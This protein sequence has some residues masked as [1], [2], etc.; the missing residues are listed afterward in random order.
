MLTQMKAKRA[1]KF[2]RQYLIA[3]YTLAAF[4]LWNLYL[5]LANIY[6]GPIPLE[7]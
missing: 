1:Q 7:M 5:L 3:A 6:L 4:S 2:Y